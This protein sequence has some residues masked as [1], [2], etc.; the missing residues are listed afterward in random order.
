MSDD[1]LRCEVCQRDHFEVPVIEK[2]FRF[3]HEAK[4]FELPQINSNGRNQD[5]IC[6]P[7]LAEEIDLLKECY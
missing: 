7:C 4:V 5:N 2:P 1:R 3:C 6:L